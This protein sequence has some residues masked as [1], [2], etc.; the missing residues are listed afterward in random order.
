MC[1]HGIVAG[2]TNTQFAV[3]VHVLTYLSANGGERPVSS[4]E[5]SGSTNTNPVYVRRVLGPL[6]EAG[7]VHARQGS[8]GGWTLGRPAE[9]IA[10]VEVWSL[11]Q[12]DEPVL[13]LHGPNPKCPIGAGIQ[14]ALRELDAAVAAALRAELG[15]RTIA[16]LVRQS[17]GATPVRRRRR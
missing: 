8:Q 15:R 4:D 16:D 5:L 14:E 11:L 6:R 10:L 7:L 3:A 1:D 9:E 2:P 17:T 12:G 13:G